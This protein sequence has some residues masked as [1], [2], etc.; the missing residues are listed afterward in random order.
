MFLIEL[1][2][3]QVS[4]P[5]LQERWYPVHQSAVLLVYGESTGARI[6]QTVESTIPH[7][8]NA[9]PENSTNLSSHGFLHATGIA[10]TVN[11]MKGCQTTS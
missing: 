11:Q 1:M 6:V 2:L 7:Q 10:I 9:E 4:V 3:R 5:S 8:Y